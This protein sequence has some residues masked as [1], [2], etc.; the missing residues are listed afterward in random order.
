LFFYPLP[1]AILSIEKAALYTIYCHLEHF[2]DVMMEIRVVDINLT[3]DSP[4]VFAS[5]RT[6]GRTALIPAI[7][8]DPMSN[9]NSPTPSSN[10]SRM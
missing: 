2:D 10:N 8:L 6:R 9:N 4:T 5:Y 3:D 7:F 1:R